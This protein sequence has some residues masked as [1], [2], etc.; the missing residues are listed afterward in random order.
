M[1]NLHSKCV[2]QITEIQADLMRMGPEINKRP[3][4]QAIHAVLKEASE[5]LIQLL[6]L[7]KLGQHPYQQ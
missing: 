3:D 1:E 5:K 6:Y 7:V 4:I 2:I